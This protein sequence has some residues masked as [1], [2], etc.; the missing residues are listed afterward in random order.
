MTRSPADDDGD[1]ID[2]QNRAH[3][4]LFEHVGVTDPADWRT[5]A[6]RLACMYQPD[7]VTGFGTCEPRERAKGGR[8]KKWNEFQLMMADIFVEKV[9]RESS[10]GT[11]R[12]G[13]I[14]NIDA[15][16]FIVNEKYSDSA[17]MRA[18]LQLQPNTDARTLDNMRREGAKL[19]AG[20]KLY[21][22]AA[23]EK[24]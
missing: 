15:C 4:A 20:A 3:V 7:L 13:L 16:K 9:K 10:K 17:G 24:G 6:L 2:A 22:L 8:P 18:I 19:R 21:R 23:N 1:A 12:P 14:T 11:I 5:V